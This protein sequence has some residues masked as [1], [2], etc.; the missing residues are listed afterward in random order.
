MR[1]GR[2]AEWHS[3]TV[4]GK[5]ERVETFRDLLVWQRGMDIARSVY[6]ETARMPQAE[7][8]G[9]TSQMRRA[10]TSIPMNIAEGFGRRTRP[11]LIHGL[12]I[13]MGSLLELMTAYELATTMGLIKATDDTLERLAEED[14]LLS[15]LIAKLEA[16]PKVTKSTPR[17]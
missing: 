8:F 9:L 15:S 16:K 6:A 12:R 7:A 4:K 5:P 2:V 11:E 10:A 3:G 13:A 17:R 1:S 14:R